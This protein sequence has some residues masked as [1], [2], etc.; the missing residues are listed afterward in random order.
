MGKSERIS[1]LDNLKAVAIFFVVL[2]H[3]IGLPQT[4]Y[5]LIFAFHMP[6]FFWM[7]GLLLNE[8]TLHLPFS[9]FVRTRAVKLL[10]PYLFFA[11][12]SYTAWLFL[13][14]HFGTQ[15]DLDISPVR[16]LLGIVYGNGIQ[17]WMPWN[18]ALWFFLCLFVTEIIF[19]CLARLRS[20]RVLAGVLGL[21]AVIGYI[22]TWLNPPTG[23]RLPWNMDIALTTVVFYGM[24]YLSRKWIFRLALRPAK[25][26]LWALPLVVLYTL[27]ALFNS[28]VALVAGV[29]GNFILFYTAAFSGI[30]FWI[31]ASHS[32]PNWRILQRIGANTLT[33]FASHL[34][35]FPLLTGVMVYAFGL[36]AELKR[37]SILVSLAF[38]LVS[39]ALLLPVAE[40]LNRHLPLVV[41]IVPQR[42]GT[43]SV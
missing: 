12:L 29:Y 13:F 41:G 4:W 20:Q 40:W 17:N 8:Q 33:I 11:L 35:L 43:R 7:S 24:G 39:I 5:R 34:L 21:L 2:E 14:R 15:A 19:Y 22:D 32:M 3:T 31:L 23:F 10:I 37:D 30:A 38:T 9:R 27:S 6:I 42:S 18:T 28:K 16:S 1:W 26:I 25:A 36:P